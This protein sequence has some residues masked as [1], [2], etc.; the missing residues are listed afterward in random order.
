MDHR[1]RLGLSCIFEFDD[2]GNA[3]KQ[4]FKPS[5]I[6]DQQP[7]GAVSLI[8]SLTADGLTLTAELTNNSPSALGRVYGASAFVSLLVLAHLTYHAPFVDYRTPVLGYA[9]R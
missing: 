6:S 3:L 9:Q 4:S 5:A 8:T 1:P 2:L 7:E